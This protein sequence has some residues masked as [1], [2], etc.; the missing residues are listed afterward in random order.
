MCGPIQ[1]PEDRLGPCVASL[2]RG[3]ANA[4]P[5]GRKMHFPPGMQVERGPLT[6]QEQARALLVHS[7]IILRDITSLREEEAHRE[8]EERGGQRPTH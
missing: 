5:L 6:V 7:D 4:I 8:W 1:S 3:P 2:L